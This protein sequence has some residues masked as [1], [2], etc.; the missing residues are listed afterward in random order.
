MSGLGPLWHVLYFA[1]DLFIPVLTNLKLMWT[2]GLPYPTLPMSLN[3]NNP[4]LHFE[5]QHSFQTTNLNLRVFLTLQYRLPF[6]KQHLKKPYENL[7][8]F[9][10]KQ[11]KSPYTY[12][13]E[14]LYI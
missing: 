3:S 9:K 6:Q 11:K 4:S 10:R 14:I 13:I 2:T 7:K 12:K 1:V 8:I 5:Q